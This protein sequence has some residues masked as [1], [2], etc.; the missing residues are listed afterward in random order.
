MDAGA[1]FVYGVSKKEWNYYGQELNFRN[2]YPGA[3]RAGAGGAKKE[4]R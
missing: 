4:L 3:D 2:G 1:G